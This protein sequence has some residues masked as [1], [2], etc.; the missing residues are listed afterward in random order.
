MKLNL[1]LIIVLMF[2]KLSAQTFNVWSDLRS[3]AVT[4]DS[5]IHVRCETIVGDLQ[6][7][8]L[9]YST[10]DGWETSIMQSLGMTS[11]ESVIPYY[12]DEFVS[13]RLR[14]EI[15]FGFLSLILMMPSFLRDTD[16]PS[17]ISQMALVGDD[18]AG[19]CIID[20]ANLDIIHEYFSFS[21]DKFISGIKTQNGTYPYY[22]NLWGPYYF[23]MTILAN[24]ESALNDSVAYAMLYANVPPLFTPGLYRVVGLNLTEYS[25]IGDIE[26][27]IID[28]TL[29]LSCDISDLANDEYFGNWPN[30]SNTLASAS[31]TSQFELP[32][33]F[34]LADSGHAAVQQFD[35]CYI[36][37]LANT[38][39][40]ISDVSV[41][42]TSEI[43]IVNVDYF[44]ADGNF[45][46][47]AEAVVNG[48]NYI[49]LSA[50]SNNFNETVS[51]TGLI[52][53]EWENILIRF[54][55]NNVD[56]TEHL[57]EQTLAEDNDND[58]FITLSVYPNPIKIGSLL[59]DGMKFAIDLEKKSQVKI[60]IFNLKGQVVNSISRSS[61][62][63]G[64]HTLKWS[65]KDKNGKAVSSG[66]YLSRI[67]S[68]GISKTV[69]IMIL[70]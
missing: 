32:M 15:D 41:N 14:T 2:V 42:Q 26:H 3:S 60:D 31:I 49:E 51:F 58:E 34:T 43:S 24:P 7:T 25:R 67:S 59:D 48:N 36:N 69:K 18:E 10:E 35:Y 62:N 27:Q 70:K 55:D 57:I 63:S 44:D 50:M 21:D 13:M 4:Q 46:L 52:E 23:Y 45:P 28:G 53:E 8:E 29:V 56:F 39:P 68:S 11:L 64:S 1:V 19:D 16:F 65:G 61:L 38:L 30:V 9:H 6:N 20:A 22:E 47:T 54:S 5:T 40:E 66:I 33:E 37:A 17:D 12:G